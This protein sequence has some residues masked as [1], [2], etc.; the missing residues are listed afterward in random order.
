[1]IYLKTKEELEKMAWSGKIAARAMREVKQLIKPGIT[2]L[3]I[4]TL[5]GK[6]FSDAGVESAFKKVEDYKFNICATVND[7][8]VHG[9]PDNKPLISGDIVGIDLGCIF[10]G[11][12]SD[13]AH[14]F[15][16]GKV[17]EKVERF[18][19]I[20]EETLE[21][22]IKQARPGQR[23]GD[24]SNEIQTNIEKNGYSVVREFVGHGIGKNL[25]EE[26]WVPGF[27]KKGVGKKIEPGLVI[28]IEVIYNQKGPEVEMLD[29]GWT[30]VTKDGSISGLFERTVAITREGPV[31]LTVE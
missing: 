20:G 13:M 2:T 14:T 9:L 16:V 8:V 23:I 7:Q 26:P 6:I 10:E 4:D 11:F 28:A 18:L 1:M 24:I 19:K 3:E 15:P 31:V 29:D 27:G 12:N 30:I 21:K 17:S 25:H 22:A 5:V